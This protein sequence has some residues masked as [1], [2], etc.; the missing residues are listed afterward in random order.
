MEEPEGGAL[1]WQGWLKSGKDVGIT[2][3]HMRNRASKSEA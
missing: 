2:I 1:S 3:L